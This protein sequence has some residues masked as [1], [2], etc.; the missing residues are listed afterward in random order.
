[1]SRSTM[2]GPAS[3]LSPAN[4]AHPANPLHPANRSQRIVQHED[5]D[6]E[7]PARTVFTEVEPSRTTK[8]C[9]AVLVGCGI[10]VSVTIVF[11]VM[12]LCRAVWTIFRSR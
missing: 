11:L 3:F 10:A 5:E 12:V 6:H 4:P 2:V 9:D 7:V 1:M 8:V